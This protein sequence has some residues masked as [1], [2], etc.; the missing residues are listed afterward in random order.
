MA[1]RKRVSDQ[2]DAVSNEPAIVRA[3]LNR[4]QEVS[5][6]FVSIY[7]NDAQLQTTPWDIRIVFGLI[8]GLPSH[9][10]PSVVVKQVGEVRMSPQLAK[11]IATILVGQLDHYEK[12]IGPIPMPKD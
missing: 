11:K 7:A 3:N 1:K 8:T 12:V 4:V 6:D 10:D 9:D 5:P 2:P